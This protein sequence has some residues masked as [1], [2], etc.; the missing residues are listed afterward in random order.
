MRKNDQINTKKEAKNRAIISD[1]EMNERIANNICDIIENGNVQEWKKGWYTPKAYRENVLNLEG[2]YDDVLNDLC[3]VNIYTIDIFSWQNGNPIPSGF[4]VNFKQIKAK[5]L[6]LKKG[7]KGQP[8]YK[9]R[10]FEKHLT[11]DETEALNKL[12][13]SDE[14]L[15]EKYNKLF[16][17]AYAQLRVQFDYTSSKTGEIRHFDENIYVVNNVVTYA[18]FQYVLEYQFNINDLE[19]VIDVKKLWQISDTKDDEGLENKQ[20]KRIK[21]AEN[22]KLDYI[23][24]ANLKYNEIMQD[25]AFYSP[26]KHSV[27]VPLAQQFETMP[28]YYQTLFHELAHSTGHKTLLNRTGITRDWGR[29]G[30]K[31]YAK[32]ELVA[33]LSSIFTLTTLKLCNDEVFKN[34]IAY[35]KSW[36]SS[37][38]EG[39][40]HN[41]INTIQHSQKATNLI[42]N[43]Q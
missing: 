6:K 40:K 41:I 10:K 33:E 28:E 8:T 29:W 43:I 30:D 37:L 4:Y 7:A 31:T 5:N 12:L 21:K 20:I 26:S 18:R 13:E 38:N 11:Q 23:K 1:Y 19:T 14:E 34:S 39:I 24:R 22:V 3:A 36:G 42:L 25:R 15:Q 16:T 2:L 9:P 27:T 35:L 32:E 17:S